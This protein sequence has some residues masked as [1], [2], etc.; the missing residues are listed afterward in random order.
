MRLTLRG[1]IVLFFISI[2]M[3]TGAVM[4][5][6]HTGFAVK[7][8]GKVNYVFYTVQPNDTLWEIAE[9]YTQDGEDV[10]KTLYEIKKINDID[11][12]D[13]V[14]GMRLAVLKRD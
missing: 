12:R 1:K 13:I 5:S 6:V 3:I 4:L 11:G 10:R 14:A 9:K 7:D 2:M 8:D